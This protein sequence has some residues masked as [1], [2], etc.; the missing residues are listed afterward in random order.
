VRAPDGNWIRFA[1][2]LAG[3]PDVVERLLDAHQDD[4]TG[5]CR[6]CTTPGRGT[7]K[8]VWP[9]GIAAIAGIAARLAAE[10]ARGHGP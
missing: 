10:R 2:A 3:M 8:T 4:G 6:A 7:P 1:T 9:C 5:R